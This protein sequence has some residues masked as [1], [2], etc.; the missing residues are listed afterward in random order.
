[1]RVF[2]DNELSWKCASTV[3]VNVAC[4][5]HRQL[6]GTEQSLFRSNVESAEMARLS[7]S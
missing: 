3:T 5:E 7:I 2:R 6:V 4:V 1:M